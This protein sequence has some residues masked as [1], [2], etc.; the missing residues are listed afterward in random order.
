MEHSA[1]DVAHGKVVVSHENGVII[2][3]DNT[4]GNPDSNPNNNYITQLH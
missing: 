4:N 2:T 1:V 3:T